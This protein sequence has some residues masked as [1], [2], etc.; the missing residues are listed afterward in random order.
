MLIKPYVTHENTALIFRS[1]NSGPDLYY[2]MDQIKYH[3]RAVIVS[4]YERNLLY[5]FNNLVLFK[6]ARTAKFQLLG[7]MDKDMGFAHMH[8]PWNKINW[9]KRKLEAAFQPNG[10]YLA[11]KP[12]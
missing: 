8:R 3:L 4:A 9:Q 11:I 12:D 2:N 10:K 7:T 1:A 5:L 6:Q